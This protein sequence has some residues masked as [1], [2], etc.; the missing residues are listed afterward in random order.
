MIIPAGQRPGNVHLTLAAARATGLRGALARTRDRCYALQLGLDLDQAV[1]RV[2]DLVSDL[3]SDGIMGPARDL[4]LDHA[5]GLA[6]EL[7]GSAGFLR[8][9]ARRLARDDARAQD[10]AAALDVACLLA[11]A[12]EDAL[13][14]AAAKFAGPP[15][16]KGTRAFPSARLL[17]G[18]ARARYQE[19]YGAELAELAAAGASRHQ[20]VRYT[21][22][23]LARSAWLRAVLARARWHRAAA[24]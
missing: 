9:R 23:L 15:A 14:R 4:D 17:P 24:R 20:Q 21:L 1:G 18:R 5:R 16:G 13:T 11:S 8:A 10:I 2:H 19:E 7:T 22:R 3:N 12:C 6:A